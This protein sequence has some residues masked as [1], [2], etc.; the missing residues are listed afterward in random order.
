MAIRTNPEGRLEERFFGAL[1]RL[2]PA[3]FRERFAG[4]MRTLFRD[5]QR[6]ARDA[7][8][9]AYVRFFWDTGR[10][11]V[12]TAFREHQEIL[13][14]DADYALRLMRKDMSFTIV[15]IGILGMAIGAST[16]AFMAANAILIQ[17]L[18]FSGGNHLIHLQQ[19]R[20]AIGVE[21][22]AFSVKEIEDYRSQ[23]HT[24]DSVVEFHEMTFSLLGGR[25][26]VRVDTGVVSANFF[27]IL[28]VT[29][30]YGRTFMDEDD[31][32]NARPVLIL[33]YNFWQKSFAGDPN[34][35]GQKYSMNDKE[36]IVV[37]ILP[38]IPQ[39]PSEVDVY[40]PTVACPTRSG[41]Y[42]LHERSWHMMNVYATLKPGV[43]LAEAQA[44]LNQIA[45]RLQSAYPDEYPS[46]K[47]YEIGLQPVHEEL[48]HDIRPVLIVLAAAVGL[49]LLLACANVT[50]I[51]VSRMLARTRE[52]TVR[53]ILGASRS[54]ILRGM[55][56]EG[57]MLAIFG[58]MVGLILAYWSVG[59]LVSLTSKF[60]SLASQ[61]TF[62]PQVI[63]FGFLLSVAC[64]FV[65][66]TVPSIGV[67]YTALFAT[68]GG[69]AGL[70]RGIS[71]RTRGALVAAQ[72]AVCVIL[73][74]WAGLALRT[75]LHLQR[76][77][78]G[79][80]PSGVLTARIYILNGKHQEFFRELLERTRRLPGV[81]SAGL[82]ST[83]P[84]H[85]A[86]SDGPVPIEVREAKASQ[87]S[88]TRPS[89]PVIRIV[90]PDYFRTLGASI[91]AGR[92]FNDQDTN[93]GQP[94]V[95]VNQHMANH[96]WPN[97]NAVGK[98]VAIASDKWLPIVGVVSDIR[99]LGLDQD[100]VDEMYG[101]LAE[102][103]QAAMS[104]VIRS[105]QTSPELGEQLK[106]IA[107]DI[108]P[109][110]VVADVH[111]LMQVRQ[112]WLASRRTT[113][114]FLGIFAVVALCITASGISG[115]M[116][117]AVGERKHEIGVRL[118][119]GAT[120]GTVILSMMKQV[121][122]LM[123][124]GLGV[125]FGVAWVMSTSMS[126]LIAGIAP[127]DAVTFAVS[128]GLLIAVTTASSFVP[129]TRIAKL[130]PAVLLRAE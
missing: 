21:R 101:S 114:M 112:E 11:L 90:T 16:A 8:R 70:S 1:V 54:R 108:D 44:D 60:T 22:M 118:A 105:S 32:P 29:P 40:M 18:P 95:V 102:S 123:T 42:A 129:L 23:N 72:L 45:K 19:R 82:A 98:Q 115:M 25:E 3:E 91:L 52:L 57:V 49:L 37:G 13:F 64:G 69:N 93:E 127:R 124:A 107:H 5:Q 28:G 106:W 99:H 6:D 17:P 33:S 116:A 121:L 130:D 119:L 126:H 7:G 66:G 65:I 62:T 79:F 4:E 110:A 86:A 67:R 85:N 125:G 51:M 20:P 84:L 111:P 92:D 26:P 109:N 47:G 55:V 39:F 75:V 9:L 87:D 10:G 74:V 59:L 78:P 43:S 35:V 71:S 41:E 27:R 30:L 61:L 89:P 15:V 34:V 81:V 50:G 73:L 96:Y 14:Q 68:E 76:V 24:L 58:G 36:H 2:F 46:T 56:T 38:P 103:P 48:S 128:S 31:R 63:A 113:A 120:P 88:E 122:L 94:V 117:L 97:G 80:Q 83:I 100:P 77:D 12:A 53:T 104:V